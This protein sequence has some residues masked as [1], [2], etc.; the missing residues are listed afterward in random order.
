MA[1]QQ[2]QDQENNGGAPAPEDTTPKK[3]AAKNALVHVRVLR[4]ISIGGLTIRPVVDEGPR[5]SGRPVQVKPVE[6]YIPRDLAESIGER[7]VTIL[8]HAPKGAKMGP[9]EKA[10]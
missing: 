1:K 8:G 3:A 7:Y 9:I 2:A 6:A 5:A 10:A 4:A